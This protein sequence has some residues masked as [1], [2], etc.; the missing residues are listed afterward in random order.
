MKKIAVLVGS[1]RKK[2]YSKA[3]A[4]NL[5]SLAPESLRLEI[6]PIDQ[7]PFFNQDWEGDLPTPKE[8]EEFRQAIGEAD[9]FI[10]VTPEYNRSVPALIKNAVDVASR[11]PGQNKWGGKPGLIISN[12][13]GSIS[14]F[15]AYQIL[16]QSV[17]MLGVRLMSFPELFIGGVDKLFDD[18][19]KISNELTREFLAD[20]LKKFESWV[21]KHVK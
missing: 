12:S 8:V 14:G 6:V 21:N 10:F 4:N 2:S 18:E 1:Q 13:P 19:G 17:G 16:R 7:L 15:G 5:V 20:S 3:L 9:G 11:P